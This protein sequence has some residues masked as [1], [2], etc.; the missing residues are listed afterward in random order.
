MASSASV[1]SLIIRS[2]AAPSVSRFS[3]FSCSDLTSEN[4]PRLRWIE[5]PVTGEAPCVHVE[6]LSRAAWREA[7]RFYSLSTG[8]RAAVTAQ[9][10]ALS[11]SGD[12]LH[13]KE[14]EAPT[15]EDFTESSRNQ[16]TGQGICKSH[17]G[18]GRRPHACGC[19]L[20]K[21]RRVPPR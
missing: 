11:G 13:M 9:R 12:P 6:R 5:Y 15:K 1:I 18:A 21:A 16:V 19:F 14:S 2:R 4:R 20:G 8:I 10:Y 3:F 7:P 17:S